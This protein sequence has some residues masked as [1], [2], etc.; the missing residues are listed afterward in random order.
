MSV[1]DDLAAEV[2]AK[3]ARHC[4]VCRRFAPLH[5]QVHHIKEK[6]AGGEDTFDNLIAICLTCHSDVHAH[7]AFTR[8]FT[9]EELRQ[10]RDSVYRLVK[11]GKLCPETEASAGMDSALAAFVSVY[12]PAVG[13]D[14]RQYTV[15]ARAPLSALAVRLLVLA[16]ESGNGAILVVE[17]NEGLVVKVGSSSLCETGNHRSEAECRDALRELEALGLVESPGP[18]SQALRVTHCGCLLADEILA[19]GQTR[20]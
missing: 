18:G 6:S 11:E 14:R 3:C 1:P 16:A 12:A 9:P 2:L 5:L 7:V 13:G 15:P 17:L 8:R 10:H 4:C 19:A 20:S